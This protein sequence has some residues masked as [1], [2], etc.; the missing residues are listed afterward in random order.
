MVLGGKN[1]TKLDSYLIFHKIRIP[2][3]RHKCTKNPRWCNKKKNWD[4]P[5]GPVLVVLHSQCRGP[6]FDPWSGYWIP[7]AST[8]DPTHGNE[9][10]ACRN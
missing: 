3:Y 9:D 5:G 6:G 2:I 10:P 7:H 1:P 4:F 8:K